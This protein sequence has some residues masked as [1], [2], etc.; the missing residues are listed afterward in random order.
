MEQ[1][2]IGLD[3]LLEEIN[4]D[5]LKK[6]SAGKCFGIATITRNDLEKLKATNKKANIKMSGILTFSEDIT[7]ELARETIESVKV[8]GTIKVSDGVKKV[9]NIL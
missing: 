6:S 1:R 8:R 5:I 3:N 2:I 7:P 9:L 4:E